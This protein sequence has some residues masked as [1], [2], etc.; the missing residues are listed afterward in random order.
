VWLRHND[1]PTTILAPHRS[2]PS[3]RRGRRESSSPP[4]PRPVWKVRAILAVGH[5]FGGEMTM[6]EWGNHIK[7]RVRMRAQDPCTGKTRWRVIGVDACLAPLVN[8]LNGAWMNV[9]TGQRGNFPA[10]ST[11]EKF[12]L[13]IRGTRW[14]TAMNGY[15]QMSANIYVDGKRTTVSLSGI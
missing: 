11:G 8:A 7:C 12:D 4:H 2:R 10:G 3:S 15:S 1:H 14:A 13:A 5:F 6:C 9:A